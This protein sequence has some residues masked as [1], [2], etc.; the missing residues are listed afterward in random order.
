[1]FL[2]PERNDKLL[3]EITFQASRSSGAGGQNVNK[4]NTKVELRFAI[5][6]SIELTEV[7]KELLRNKFITR[8]NEKDE[9]IIVAQTERS[10]LKNK[11]IAIEKFFGFLEKAFTPQKKR[12]PTK[13]T[14]TSVAK[15]LES[16]KKNSEKKAL[17]RRTE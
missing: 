8:I 13:P 3:N 12:K 7:E 11:E 15:R 16:K 4:V 14:R 17:R 2:S 5:T 6:Q 1:M 10:Q 9:L